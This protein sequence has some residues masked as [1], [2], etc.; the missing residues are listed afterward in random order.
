MTL[1]Q[2]RIKEVER[3]ERNAHG[4]LFIIFTL[5]KIAVITGMFYGRVGFLRCRHFSFF[6]TQREA[7]FNLLVHKIRRNV[8][9]DGYKNTSVLAKIF[10]T[11]LS[12]MT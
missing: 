9:P 12:R 11:K 7:C 10:A 4:V 5:D 2:N 3:K 8:W 6:R 1:S